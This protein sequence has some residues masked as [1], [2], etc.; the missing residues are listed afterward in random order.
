MMANAAIDDES[1]GMVALGVL[2][3]L[4]RCRDGYDID[5]D[6]LAK[7]RG[8]GRRVLYTAMR[9]LVERAYVVKIKHQDARGRW[10]TDAFVFDTPANSYEVADILAEFT[11]AR[12]MRV[13]PEWIDPRGEEPRPPADANPQV[14]PACQNRQVGSRQVGKRQAKDLETD[15][16]TDTKNTSRPSVPGARTRETAKVGGG[17]GGS[18]TPKKPRPVTPTEGVLLLTAIGNE[19]PAFR[20]TGRALAHQGAAVDALLTAGWTPA[21]IRDVVAGRELPENV[22]SVGAVISHRLRAALTSPPSSA[23]PVIPHEAHGSHDQRHADAPMHSSTETANRSVVESVN[24]RVQPECPGDEGLCGRPSLPETGLC[25]ECSGWARCDCGLWHP[26]ESA[27]CPA[28]QA[29]FDHAEDA[30]RRAL[31]KTP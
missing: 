2:T 19:L 17:T 1:L 30:F 31:G 16:K 22:R 27:T 14:A 25:P 7:R 18:P 20:L 26:G 4:V 21:Q 11:E 10:A 8:P 15:T 9:S 23:A 12:G 28:C 3:F 24:R 13:E 5:M 6:T 29:E